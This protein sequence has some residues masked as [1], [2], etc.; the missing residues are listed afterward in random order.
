MDSKTLN[1][2]DQSRQQGI[3]L[4]Q[5]NDLYVAG[6]NPPTINEEPHK[7]PDNRIPIPFAK[8][9]VETLSGYAGRAGDIKEHWEN[10]TT[11][12]EEAKGQGAPDLYIEL[13]KE[14]A[15]NNDT[16]LETSELY[17]TSITQ[18]VA[19]ELFWVTGADE[20]DS[21]IAIPEYSIIP[22]AEIAL[23]WST[24]IKPKLQAAVR[25]TV[26]DK[27]KYADV[28][29]PLFS[30]HWIKPESAGEWS[31]RTVETEDG[32]IPMQTNYPYK[33]VPIAIY[34]SNRTE[35]SV[36]EAEKG[37]IIG[38]DKMLNKSINEVDRFNA[39]ITLF[40]GA[41]TKEFIDKL[42]DV[43]S[44]DNLGD[45]EKWPEYLL[46]D[47]TGIQEFYQMVADRLEKLF[48]K[49]IK[50]PDFSDENFVDVQSGLAMAYKLLGL[51]F[52]ASTIDMYFHK[53]L[54]MRN[55]LL[56]DVI[57]ESGKIKTDDYRLIIQANRNLPVDKATAVDIVQKLIGIVSRETLLRI[58]PREIVEDVEKELL[59][60]EADA[61]DVDLDDLSIED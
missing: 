52:R 14:I 39:A 46:K 24:D 4:I 37:I 44:I 42:R 16:D 60:L 1:E 48:H 33:S 61:P 22:N 13:R 17:E 7:K 54:K 40:P 5:E 9:A 51:E 29:Y 6:K 56:N 38:N 32:F 50:I 26:H 20:S 58:L 12:A 18:G 19:Y 45:F 30:E 36:F 8:I 34:P 35:T 25:F 47:L 11:E 49:S 21:T 59:R 27:I 23:I 43:T 57:D 55:K 3:K 10:I 31:Q 53:G 28:Y 2:L 15:E 41:V